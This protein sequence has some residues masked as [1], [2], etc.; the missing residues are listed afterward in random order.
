MNKIET[1]LKLGNNMKK[2]DL[3]LEARLCVYYTL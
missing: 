3:A 1:E 2:N